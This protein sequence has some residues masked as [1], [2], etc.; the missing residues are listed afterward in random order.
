MCIQTT[1]GN[2][3][4]FRQSDASS[5]YGVPFRLEFIHL[6]EVLSPLEGSR[7]GSANL[8]SADMV[9]CCVFR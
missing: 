7:E 3:G 2:R 5:Q 8:E 4:K 9:V 6:T 1:A